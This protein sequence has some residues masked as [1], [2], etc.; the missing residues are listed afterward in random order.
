[1]ISELKKTLLKLLEEDEEFRYAVASR[2][3]LLEI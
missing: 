1:M 3:G 2:I